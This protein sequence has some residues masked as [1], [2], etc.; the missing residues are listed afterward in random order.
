MTQDDLDRIAE[1]GD[2]QGDLDDS[3][4]EG[5][6]ADALTRRAERRSATAP[7]KE[8][9]GLPL[10]LKI[11]AGAAVLLFLAAVVEIA[12]AAGRVHP[13]VRVGDVKVGGLSV[14]AA[15]ERLR[16]ELGPRLEQPVTISYGDRDWEIDAASVEATFDPAPFVESA[17]AVGRTGSLLEQVAVRAY[18]WVRP[19]A[20]PVAA[21]SGEAAT[22]AVLDL[23]SGEIRVEPR[24]ATVT[25]EGTSASIEPAKDGSDI[26]RD[27]VKAALLGA[28]LSRDRVVEATVGPVP[29]EV[30]DQDAEGALRD[31]LRMMSGPV[32]VTF[33]Q[34]EWE[35]GAG[36]IARWITFSKESRG[37][38]GPAGPAV[39]AAGRKILVAQIGASELSRT[40]IPRLGA[41]V[42]VPVDAAF[43]VSNQRVS[44]VP[45]RDGTGPDVERL[46]DDMTSA[47]VSDGQ[48]VVS[49][50]TARVKPKVSTEDA[51]AMG[52]KE[53]LATY[54]TSYA[55]SNKPRVNNIHLLAKALDGALIAPGEVFSFNGHT[56]QRTA[57]KGY[58]EA[59]AIV[60]RN[61]QL[62]L[63]P[64]LGGG[65]CQVGT[66]FF[67]TVFFSG[68][69][70]VER[71]N[72]SFYIDSY[73]KGRDATVS[74]GAPDLKF[75]NDTPDWVL[76]KTAVTA[77]TVTI[78]LY[79]TD[80]GYE[81]EYSTS[82][83][84][85]VKPHGVV[86]KKDPTMQVGSRVVEDGGVDGRTV[87]VTRIV[88]KGGAVIRMDT[89]TSVYKPKTEV[90]RVGTKP[91]S[92]TATGSPPAT[93][94]P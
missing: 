71:K 80:P 78:S 67:N 82:A 88:K 40:V 66:T 70:V 50:R 42:V 75:R 20:I 47:L 89:F 24:D 51:K 79:G 45:H 46:A 92:K 4:L 91:V 62:V 52:I 3:A 27:V 48:R 58:K 5:W 53:R 39:A 44:I 33:E 54:T 55:P 21:G 64:Q 29:V 49:L 41:V 18:A 94:T 86:E 74:W 6:H 83:F 12:A 76:V 73:P 16:A 36:D 84:R 31:A 22:G 17:Y 60:T 38:T 61:G 81:V 93:T 57:D 63:E 25:I 11:A 14:A 9:A 35:F 56:G 2:G 37:A 1:A 7:P 28:F 72:H 90:V 43:S 32:T 87:T 26:D 13:G 77:G 10:P 19:V 59:N 34:K 30:R 65:I 8:R 68:L 23:I 85:N 15:A 69:P